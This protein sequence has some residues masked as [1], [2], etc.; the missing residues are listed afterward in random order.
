MSFPDKQVLPGRKLASFSSR[1][2]LFQKLIHS[3]VAKC[4][5]FERGQQFL[6][7]PV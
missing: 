5:E 3:A 6:A 7:F 2:C 1:P 4:L